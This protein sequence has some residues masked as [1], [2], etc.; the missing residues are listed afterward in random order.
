VN[1]FFFYD[2][3]ITGRGVSFEHCGIGVICRWDAAYSQGAYPGGFL[4]HD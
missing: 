4:E 2:S 1:I 3:M